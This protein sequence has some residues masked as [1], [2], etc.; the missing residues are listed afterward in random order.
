MRCLKSSS[1]DEERLEKYLGGRLDDSENDWIFWS[2]K[3]VTS[4]VGG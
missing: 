1:E 3:R 2:E 4:S